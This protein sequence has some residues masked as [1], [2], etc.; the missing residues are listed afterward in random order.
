MSA[1]TPKAHTVA[2]LLVAV[3]LAGCSRVPSKE[4][5]A[6]AS[7]ACE[8]FY[9]E[10]RLPNWHH[11]PKAIDSW[12]KEGKLVIELAVKDGSSSSSYTPWLC[13]VDSEAGKLSMP[14]LINQGRWMK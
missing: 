5:I 12:T 8:R 2:A 13:V 9:Y 1:A 11:N 4:D 14:S 3:L 7:K 10:E 6:E